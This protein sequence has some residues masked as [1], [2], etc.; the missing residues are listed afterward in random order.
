ME[1]APRTAGVLTGK[2]FRPL[3][4]WL[5]LSALLLGWRY[6]SEQKRT[7]TITF[8][9]SVEGRTGQPSFRTELNQTPFEVGQPSGLGQKALNISAPDAETLSTNIHVGYGGA[10]L[11]NITLARSRGRLELN[12]VPA[13]MRVEVVGQEA[14]QTLSNVV[15]QSLSLPTGRYAVT[16]HFAR[17][18]TEQE[19]EITRNQN[20]RLTIDPGVVTLSLKSEPTNAEFELSLREPFEVSVRSNTPT[21][22]TGLPKG[23]YQLRIWRGDYQQRMP[24]SLNTQKQT[25]ELTVEFGYGNVTLT[26][27]PSGGEIRN[28][29]RL[30]GS[31]PLSL[32][33]AA[34]TY[35]LSIGK[36]DHATTNVSLTL[37][38]KETRTNH[39]YLSNIAF[40]QAMK[41]ARAHASGTF[42]DLDRALA[43]I[44]QAL[45]LSPAE[46]SALALKEFILRQRHLSAARKFQSEKNYKGALREVESVVQAN[47]TDTEAL[48][49]KQELTKEIQ[50][51]EA[52]EAT[53]RRELPRRILERA[54]KDVS[55]QNLFPMEELERKGEFSSVRARIIEGLERTPS[56]NIRRNETASKDVAVIQAE[57]KGFGSRQSAI[58]IVSQTAK[59]EVTILFKLCIYTLSGNFQVGLTGISD[60]SYKPLH[61][62]FAAPGTVAN[63]ERRRARELDEFRKKIDPP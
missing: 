47:A 20:R 44:N 1:Q 41:N 54:I 39:V 36:P 17:F 58:V 11:G 62:S 30:L 25:N 60:D 16:T 12:V 52:S 9:V 14:R 59:N 19:V 18:S 46:P 55:H 4:A 21:L 40:V 57:T 51:V 45:A 24:V 34:G 63:V 7:A 61:P 23:E 22:I 32:T 2:V 35:L 48:N 15:A 3:L 5:A 42:A 43:E 56:W 37:R 6:H 28:D 49:L 38:A 26:S 10:K 53:A 27:E 31:T 13:A 8:T 50:A 33:L 29:G